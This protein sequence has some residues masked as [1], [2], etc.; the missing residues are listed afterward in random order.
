MS[1]KI[2]IIENLSIGFKS[3]NGR[4]VSIL[5]DISTQS[6]KVRLLVL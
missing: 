3:Q 5:K 4:E 1:D 6:I 2:Q